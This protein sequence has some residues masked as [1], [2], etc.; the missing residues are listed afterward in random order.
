MALT[1]EQRQQILNSPNFQGLINKPEPVETTEPLGF[2][3][4]VR[5]ARTQTAL[6]V[7]PTLPTQKKEEPSFFDRLKETGGD[8]KE[9]IVDV[10]KT[11][12]ETKEKIGDIVEGEEAGEQGKWRSFAQAFGTIAG[13]LSKAGGN[14]IEGGIKAVLSQEDEEKV[15][16]AVASSL[17]TIAPIAKKVDEVV[18]SPVGTFV[19]NYKNLDDKSKRDIDSLLGISSLSFDIATAGVTKKVGGIGVKE[20]KNVLKAGK[21]AVEAG[22]DVAKKTGKEV[23]ETV[24]EGATKF[25]EKAK[26]VVAEGAEKLKT[27]VKTKE[28][29]KS[30]ID[31]F[32]E[33]KRTY[34]KAE[35]SKQFKNTKLRETLSDPDVFSGLTIK[36]GKLNPDNAI[37]TLND[38]VE[39]AIKGKTEGVKIADET[40]PAISKNKL[41]DEIAESLPDDIAPEEL[42]KLKIQIEK[43]LDGVPD[44]MTTGQLDTLRKQFRKSGVNAKGIQKEK[45][46]FE[47]LENAT[48]SLLFKKLDELPGTKGEFAGV[49]SLIK[50]N[51]NVID[52]LNNTARGHIVTS[53]KMTKMLS[54]MGG[55][56]IGGGVGGPFGG[57]AGAV[58][59]GK[60]ADIMANKAL[61]NSLKKE[62][63]KKLSN[64]TPEAIKKVE[65]LLEK[66]PKNKLLPEAEQKLLEAGIIKLP[67]KN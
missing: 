66:I 32:V 20:T 37:K 55:I 30:A 25:G 34:V 41:I 58:G 13:G 49:S 15:K 54:Q 51:L 33:S 12:G 36:D 65:E 17:K 57:L 10:G 1:P 26:K 60:V 7:A 52:F 4:R 19:E 21:E 38:R 50:N 64:G 9:T 53:G 67:S 48:R 23:A 31:K 43:Q 6:P 3:E 16:K 44:S 59:A 11:I 39:R 42:R 63:L 62:V 14:I 61:G 40:L 2:V 28:S 8:I 24:K 27:D 56:L 45:G 35:N 46:H 5:Q 47:V 29:I 22:V 18:G